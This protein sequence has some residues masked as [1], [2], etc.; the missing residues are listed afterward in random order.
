[1]TQAAPRFCPNCG[2]P[3]PAGQRFCSNCGT[4][5]GSDT[6]NPNVFTGGDQTYPANSNI[7][8]PPAYGSTVPS[9]GNQ[10][11]QPQSGVRNT[12][13]YPATVSASGDPYSLQSSNG[14]DL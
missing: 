5:V 6:N 8:N 7:Q 14:Q 3:A 1:M 9:P 2:T 13:P 11:Y 12:P 10:A 4:T